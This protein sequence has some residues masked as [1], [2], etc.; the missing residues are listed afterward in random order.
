VAKELEYAEFLGE[1]FKTLEWEEEKFNAKIEQIIQVLNKNSQEEQELNFNQD[2]SFKDIQRELHRLTLYVDALNK[3]TTKENEL[4]YKVLKLQNKLK[5]LKS[6]FIIG[7]LSDSDLDLQETSYTNSPELLA[8]KFLLF[9][10]RIVIS[11]HE[12]KTVYIH[13]IN[14]DIQYLLP[15][16]HRLY[17]LKI[18]MKDGKFQKIACYKNGVFLFQLHCSFNKTGI[19][20]RNLAKNFKVETQ[21]G[22][23]PHKWVTKDTL[24]YIGPKPPYEVFTN[25]LSAGNN[26]SK[27]EWANDIPEVFDTWKL[28]HEYLEGDIKATWEVVKKI[29]DLTWDEH[30]IS[31][32]SSL[33]AP[34]LAKRL[35]KQKFNTELINNINPTSW[36]DYLIRLCYFGGY[37]EVLAPQLLNGKEY[38]VNSEYPFCM[39][40]DMPIGDPTLI[41]NPTWKD[42]KQPDKLWFVKAVVYIPPQ[43]YPPIPVRTEAGLT[44]PVGIVECTVAGIELIHAVEKYNC[45]IIK[46]PWGVY[47]KASN[48]PFKEYVHTL[49]NK[50]LQAKKDQNIA[51]SEVLKLF[52]NSLYGG[53][54]QHAAVFMCGVIEASHVEDLEKVHGVEMDLTLDNNYHLVSYK[55][56]ADYTI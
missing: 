45:R 12:L 42:I 11:Q 25:Q 10:E 15:S 26:I 37:Q 32:H 49:Y 43:K 29:T 14:F 22:H 23:W 44:H 33:T 4:F 41:S 24:H 20:L 51:L 8:I 46:I 17:D 50:R 39:Q 7:E 34:S 1:L 2:T 18:T 38:D 16:L 31:F 5:L 19:S 27:E 3:T 21:K 36:A 35:W 52:M 40:K 53:F 6:Q 47:F 9:L 13:N 28:A 56:G 30:G 48:E 55:K 54:A